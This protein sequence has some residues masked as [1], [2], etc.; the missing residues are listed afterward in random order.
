MFHPGA[1]DSMF[2]ENEDELVVEANRFINTLMI[3]VS[4]LEIFG[5]DKAAHSV[6]LQISMESPSK[7]LI[8]ARVADKAGVVITNKKSHIGNETPWDSLEKNILREERLQGYGLLSEPVYE[9]LYGTSP[10]VTHLLT[11]LLHS[12]QC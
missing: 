2:R 9:Y 11:F 7:G 5:R 3:M 6:P 8:L 1:L 12:D 10:G 4:D